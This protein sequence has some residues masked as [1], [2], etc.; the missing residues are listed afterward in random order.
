MVERFN[1]TLKNLLRKHAARFGPEW[2]RYLDG[3]LWAYRNSPH[4]STGEKPSFLLFGVDLRTPTEAALLPPTPIQP[5]T[6]ENYREELILSLS[7]ARELA[8]KTLAKSQKKSKEWYDDHKAAPR[9]FRLG[10]WVSIKF[11]REESGKNRKLS[12][13]WHGPY[14]VVSVQE[15]DITAVKVYKPQDKQIQVHMSRVTPW[16]E[17]ITPGY[18][19]YGNRRDRPG[20]PPKWIDKLTPADA[21]SDGPKDTPPGTSSR[22]TG[23]SSDSR[24]TR[25]VQSRY[26]LRSQTAQNTT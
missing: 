2:D 11:P 13:P 23:D 22:E 18:Y 4:E 20:R 15:P 10:D 19:W 21:P 24:D 12:H 26:H 25:P 17:G 7:S 8:C 5:D 16:P 14:R 9:S 6:V 1:R 3:V